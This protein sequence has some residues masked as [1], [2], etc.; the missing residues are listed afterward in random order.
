[1]AIRWIADLFYWTWKSYSGRQAER[2]APTTKLPPSEAGQ[3]TE[4]VHSGSPSEH[5]EAGLRR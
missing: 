3:E 4:G 5:T 1:M 2:G